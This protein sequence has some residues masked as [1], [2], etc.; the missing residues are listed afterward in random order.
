MITLDFQP[1]SIVED[2]GFQK[3][4]H[5]LNPSYKLPT[6]QTVSKTL[7]PALYETCLNNA[8]NAAQ[9]ILKVCIT[10]RLLDI[11]Q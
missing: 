7:I 8:K 4:V 3:F 5:S 1:F 9:K 11:R 6:R 10:Y 2:I